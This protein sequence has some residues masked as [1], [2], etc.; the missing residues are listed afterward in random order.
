MRNQNKQVDDQREKEY[1]NSIRKKNTEQGMYYN[2]NQQLFANRS[3]STNTWGGK[4]Y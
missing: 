1:E 3:G 4:K 2:L